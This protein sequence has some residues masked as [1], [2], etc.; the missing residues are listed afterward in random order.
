MD[1]SVGA[2]LPGWT[3]S[4]GHELGDRPVALGL[5]H[6][7]DPKSMETQRC[8]LSGTSVDRPALLG[9]LPFMIHWGSTVPTDSV[10]LPLVTFPLL[11][12]GS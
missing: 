10:S 3:K 11:F 4:H 2:D 5:P 6:P 8:P 12:V 9:P 1:W 7:W